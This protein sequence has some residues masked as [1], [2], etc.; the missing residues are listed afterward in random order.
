MPARGSIYPGERQSVHNSGLDKIDFSKPD[1]HLKEIVDFLYNNTT[2][3]QN[4]L[5][6]KRNTLT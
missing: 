1:K 5:P 4:D 6:K 2:M 3:T